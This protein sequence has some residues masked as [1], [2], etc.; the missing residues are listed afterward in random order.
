MLIR[1]SGAL[2]GAGM[3]AALRLRERRVS[4]HPPPMGV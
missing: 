4:P 1:S 3:D 2:G